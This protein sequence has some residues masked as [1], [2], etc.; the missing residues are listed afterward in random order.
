[1]SIYIKSKTSASSLS[2]VDNAEVD[3]N[4]IRVGIKQ[5][6]EN[7]IINYL[8]NLYANPSTAVV[9]ELFT[10][11]CDTSSKNSKINISIKQDK[12]EEGK[13]IFSITD[14]G[15]GMDKDTLENNYIQYAAS[16][17][18][19]DF[20]NVGSFGLGAK[21]PMAIVPGYK[22]ISSNGVETNEC[23][24][25]RI[26]EG[27]FANINKIG[28]GEDSYTTVEFNSLPKEKAIKMASY[29]NDMLIPFSGRNIKFDCDFSLMEYVNEVTKYTK[30]KLPKRKGYSITFYTSDD[31]GK[32]IYRTFFNRHKFCAIARVNNTPYVVEDYSTGIFENFNKAKNFIVIDVEPG[33][34][35]FAPSREEL[36]DGENLSHIK[37]ILKEKLFE[38][39]DKM[40]KFITK[41]NMI[42]K[43]YLYE[44]IVFHNDV[45]SLKDINSLCCFSEEEK[46]KINNHILFNNRKYHFA[47]NDD[48]VVAVWN[49][50]YGVRCSKRAVCRYMKLDELCNFLNNVKDI[51]NKRYNKDININK[52]FNVSIH[53]GLEFTK[54]SQEPKL[55]FYLRVSSISCNAEAYTKDIRRSIIGKYNSNRTSIYS[56]HEYNTIG[57]YYNIIVIMPKGK[58]I[59]QESIDM[60]SMLNMHWDE[61]AKEIK[62]IEPTVEQIDYNINVNSELKTTKPKLM[63][64]KYPFLTFKSNG[65]YDYG[66]RNE[67]NVNEVIEHCKGGKFF[68]TTNEEFNSNQINLIRIVTGR[69]VV[70]YKTSS[71]QIK[72][73]LEAAGINCIDA[74]KK[75]NYVYEMPDVLKSYPILND[76]MVVD[77]KGNY[78][79]NRGEEVE[80]QRIRYIFNEHP[81]CFLKA[82]ASE[83]YNSLANFVLENL[84]YFK[85][86]FDKNT[87]FIDV[88][89]TNF[90]NNRALEKQLLFDEKLFDFGSFYNNK[91]NSYLANM[92]KNIVCNIDIYIS[93]IVKEIK[94]DFFDTFSSFSEKAIKDVPKQLSERCN[95]CVMAEFS[96]DIKHTKDICRALN[97]VNSKKYA[98][99]YS[100][101]ATN[102]PIAALIQE[103][104]NKEIEEVFDQYN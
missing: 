71:K 6:A 53:E 44:R 30:V 3:S 2:T 100:N 63:D 83:S 17:K 8:T 9:R 35:A 7:L 45:S 13:Y 22:V 34:F 64:R 66:N 47:E 75:E 43:E 103:E 28:E 16:T 41:R 99:H 62:L 80:G 18:T 59:S 48:A 46:A 4:S 11:A 52:W 19:N 1:M 37:E 29:I 61:T 36:P 73:K 104:L 49:Y 96:G 79:F 69:D 24:V 40:I 54:K 90:T 70:V 101:D 98:M 65:H 56:S 58:K 92:L 15:A 26:E 77:V 85:V 5:G 94:P 74:E 38:N 32:E 89:S 87:P 25:Q 60:L 51:Y 102:D 95:E 88:F 68:Y 72:T 20:S 23:I 42:S 27:I 21:S 81:E 55:P 93:D 97:H 33:Y 12:V 67:K 50:R 84:E 82:I 78:C 31:A 10:N 91:K 57:S 39:I 76:F 14:F 86:K